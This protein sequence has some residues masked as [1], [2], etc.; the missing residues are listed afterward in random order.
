MK[1]SFVMYK[2]T[3]ADRTL[4]ERFMIPAARNA[5]RIEFGKLKNIME[6]MY[7]KNKKPLFILDIGVG[8]GRLPLLLSREPVWEKIGLYVGLDN[9]KIEIS[10]SKGL[11]KEL[12]INDKV[13][14]V[15]FDATN[16]DKK[17]SSEIF[18]HQYDLVICTYF[19]AGNFKPD[20]IKIG[21][22]GLLMPYPKSCL[23]PNKKFVKIFKAAYKLLNDKGKIVLSATYIDTDANRVRQQ[24][25][26]KDCGM[27]VVTSKRDSFTMT[28]EGFWS[29]RFTKNRV[30][31]YFSWVNKEKIKFIPLDNYNFARMIVVSK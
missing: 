10:I 31:A 22:N 20:E 23:E 21:K 11:V 12:Q 13:K 16:L 26:Y 17:D 8:N 6:E 14:I 2:G 15:Y 9:S 5:Q 19:T 29:Q 1:K 24:D 27:T 3:E 28:R 18:K 4:D 25:F 30:Y 7:S